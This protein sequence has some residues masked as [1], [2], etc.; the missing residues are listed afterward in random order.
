M[1]RELK[2]ALI[3]VYFDLPNTNNFKRMLKIECKP[4]IRTPS[5]TKNYSPVIGTWTRS[6]QVKHL[7]CSK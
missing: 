6:L 1:L 5:F 4:C 3:Q 7:M 2:H